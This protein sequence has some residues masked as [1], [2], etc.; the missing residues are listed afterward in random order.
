MGHYATVQAP[1]VFNRSYEIVARISRLSKDGRPPEGVI[2]AHGSLSSGYALYVKAGRLVLD[3]NSFGTIYRVEGAAEFPREDSYEVRF[4]FEK[5]GDLEG[6]GHLYVDD[7]LV[8]TG[9]IPKTHRY[10]I[11]WQG[12][13]VGR[14]ALS[15]VTD[16]YDGEFPFTDQIETVS[17]HLEDDSPNEAYEPA[18]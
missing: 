5:T 4:A 15:P 9:H 16:A 11:A 13:D 3:Y 12:L 10:M 7:K 2:V 8:G 14:D 6:V 18:D 1:A 17:Y